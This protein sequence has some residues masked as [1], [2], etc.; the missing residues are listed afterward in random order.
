MWN[1]RSAWYKGGVIGILIGL[2]FYIKIIIDNSGFG[3]PDV[4]G[5]GL[6]IGI[7]LSVALALSI[8]GFLIGAIIS[9]IVG[10]IKSKKKIM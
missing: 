2:L 9:W 5:F 1:N 8:I 7:N 6:T 4:A 3:N 10:K